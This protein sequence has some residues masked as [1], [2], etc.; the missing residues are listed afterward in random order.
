MVFNYGLPGSNC[1]NI[2]DDEGNV[3][4][5][6]EMLNREQFEKADI[7]REQLENANVA[8]ELALNMKSTPDIVNQNPKNIQTHYIEEKIPSAED[9]PLGTTFG[10]PPLDIPDY[11]TGGTPPLS[12]D[13]VS[14]G[15][16]FP[17]QN[18]VKGK[19]TDSKDSDPNQDSLYGYDPNE[20]WRKR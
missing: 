3:V 4:P 7:A 5:N 18:E 2:I 11:V 13:E 19:K 14:K 15:V 12:S 6:V 20:E 8:A 9:I 10:E 16:P 17:F 1:P